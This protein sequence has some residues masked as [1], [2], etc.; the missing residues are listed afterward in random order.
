MSTHTAGSGAAGTKAAAA[1]EMAA[2]LS[3]STWSGRSTGWP[4]GRATVEII[5]GSSTEHQGEKRV[6]AAL[7]SG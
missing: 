6:A 5:A 2:A 1:V 3:G 7:S 4:R